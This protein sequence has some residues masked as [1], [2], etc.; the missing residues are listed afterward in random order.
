MKQNVATESKKELSLMAKLFITITLHQLSNH[1]DDDSFDSK[2]SNPLN[3]EF[4]VCF[5]NDETT[6][7]LAGL[8]H[9]GFIKLNAHTEYFD[10]TPLTTQEITVQTAAVTKLGGKYVKRYFKAVA[11]ELKQGKFGSIEWNT[12][13]AFHQAILARLG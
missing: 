12:E 10:V 1:V 3:G 6:D 9:D 8:D 4:D 2:Y 13:G 5:L 7:A 11:D